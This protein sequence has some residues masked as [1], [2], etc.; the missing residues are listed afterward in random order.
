MED[1]DV[2]ASG[3]DAG[4][5]VEVTATADCID[6]LLEEV[7]QNLVEE[8]LL[9]SYKLGNSLMDLSPTDLYLALL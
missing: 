8:V 4:L 3:G 2:P 9:Y 1:G 5:E 7:D 6:D